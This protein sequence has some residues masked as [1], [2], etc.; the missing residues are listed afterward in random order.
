MNAA[1]PI[2]LDLPDRLETERLVLRAPRAGDGAVVHASVVETIDDL[3]AFPAS[4]PWALA[5]PTLAAAEEY[6]RRGAAHWILRT[7]LPLLLFRRADGEHVGNSG[8]HRFDW[9]NGVFETGW[10]CRRRHQRQGYI[11]E[12]VRAIVAFAFEHAGARRVWCSADDANQRSWRVAERAGFAY[13]GTLR[14][15][16]LRPTAAGAIHACTP[17]P[18]K[19]G[20]RAT[21]RGPR[22]QGSVKPQRQRRPREP[23][24]V[25]PAGA[26][27]VT[28]LARAQRRTPDRAAEGFG[29][30]RSGR[31]Q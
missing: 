19:A 9:A 4:M 6:C 3:R 24:P 11:T 12:A 28:A 31:A 18:A 21:A 25:Q 15:E 1:N 22:R 23:A 5:E 30:G 14:S 8:L 16:R 2:L 29:A 7:E 20:R 13:E 10:W 26:D 27:Q 17:L